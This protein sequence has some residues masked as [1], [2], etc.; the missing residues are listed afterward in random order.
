MHL[1]HPEKTRSNHAEKIFLAVQFLRSAFPQITAESEAFTSCKSLIVVFPDLSNTASI[2]DCSVEPFA[3]GQNEWFVR[4]EL[5]H[6]V[7][8]SYK[9][10]VSP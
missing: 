3:C 2:V 1:M 8:Q 10:I 7:G 9:L 5:T 4:S 6:P